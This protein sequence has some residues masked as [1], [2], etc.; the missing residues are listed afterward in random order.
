MQ[1]HWQ[2]RWLGPALQ[3]Y[4]MCDNVA[5]TLGPLA[6]MLFLYTDSS[7]SGLVDMSPLRGYRSTSKLTQNQTVLFNHTSLQL[8]ESKSDDW[9]ANVTNEN[10]V[11]GNG[12][13]STNL[14][15][16]YALSAGSMFAIG[17]IACCM[18]AKSGTAMNVL[19]GVPKKSCKTEDNNASGK[20]PVEIL[21]TGLI[22]TSEG[23]RSAMSNTLYGLV[24]TYMINHLRLDKMTA[25]DITSMMYICATASQL[26]TGV[27]LRIVPVKILLSLSVTTYTSMLLV[28]SFLIGEYPQI[29][30]GITG[31]CGLL[32]PTI[33]GSLYTWFNDVTEVTA[34]MT[35][36]IVAFY[37]AGTMVG[38]A[39]TGILMTSQGSAWFL[40][41][42]DAFSIFTCIMI[43]SALIVVF[44]TSKQTTAPPLQ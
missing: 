21:A 34:A 6:D 44:I 7:K 11:K 23:V 17:V 38:P 1:S 41:S 12:F 43:G 40:Y 8:N 22:M 26:L 35:S 29:I 31:I 10:N 19:S 30:W 14:P 15:E 27:L 9:M 37:A 36:F 18:W 28:S 24:V 4:F 2:G 13:Q 3:V 16:Y 39:V 25:S 33:K 20:R 5:L 42:L 32:L